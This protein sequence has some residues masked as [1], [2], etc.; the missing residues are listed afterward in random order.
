MAPPPLTDQRA[1]ALPADLQSVAKAAGDSYSDTVHQL[2]A[3]VRTQL[4][5]QVAWVSEFI[6]VHQ[7]LRFVDAA[8]GVQAPAAG[9]TIP[10]GGTF[11]ARVLDGRFPSLIPDARTVPEERLTHR[12]DP[13]ADR[14]ATSPTWP[15]RPAARP[16]RPTA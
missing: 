14:C 9:T 5:M 10:M 4:G 2:L 11:C 13:E 8:P 3:I 7:V 12:S 16:I 1:S 15:A 6:G